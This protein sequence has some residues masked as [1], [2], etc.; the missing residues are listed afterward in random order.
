MH[1]KYNT[2]LYDG[3]LYDVKSNC[4]LNAAR[5][6]L[7]DIEFVALHYLVGAE[8]DV[9]YVVKSGRLYIRYLK[10][11]VPKENVPCCEKPISIKEVETFAFHESRLVK[12]VI[13]EIV[14]ENLDTFFPY[15][16]TIVA[17]QY[18]IDEVEWGDKTHIEESYFRFF[19]GRLDQENSLIQ[20]N[21]EAFISQFCWDESKRSGTNASKDEKPRGHRWYFVD[22]VGSFLQNEHLLNVHVNYCV[23]R[24][25]KDEWLDEI[26]SAAN[27]VLRLEHMDEVEPGANDFRLCSSDLVCDFIRCLDVE[28]VIRVYDYIQFEKYDDYPQKMLEEL[29]VKSNLLADNCTEENVIKCVKILELFSEKGFKVPKTA[30]YIKLVSENLPKCYKPNR[31]IELLSCLQL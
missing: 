22:P 3:Y 28:K 2:L 31:I 11:Y 15:T 12:H 13:D 7:G 16:G 25:I 26:L 29:F 14:C 17:H 4:N 23:S 18:Y 1:E 27:P 24:R 20:H 21:D 19:E 8:A 10:T 5:L 30:C 9:R 6:V